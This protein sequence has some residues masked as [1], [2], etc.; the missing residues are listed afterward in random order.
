MGAS[1]FLRPSQKNPLADFLMPATHCRRTTSTTR[2][3]RWVPLCFSVRSP[4]AHYALGR[5][6]RLAL[7]LCMDFLRVCFEIGAR[8]QEVKRLLYVTLRYCVQ[9][10]GSAL[11]AKSRPSDPR[12]YISQ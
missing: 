10:C 5:R 9:D 1:W 12:S 7:W 3:R 11:A 8:P 6:I 2:S 4:L